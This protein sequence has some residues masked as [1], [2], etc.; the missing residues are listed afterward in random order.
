[1]FAMKRYASHVQV[2]INLLQ[3][4]SFFRCDIQMMVRNLPRL[5]FKAQHAFL[6]GVVPVCI[7]LIVLMLIQS[8]EVLLWYIWM[9]VCLGCFLVGIVQKVIISRVSSHTS[10]SSLSSLLSMA[11]DSSIDSILTNDAWASGLIAGGVLGLMVGGILF[12]YFTKKQKNRVHDETGDKPT[13]ASQ[14]KP[15]KII[16]THPLTEQEDEENDSPQ[17][18]TEE[19]IASRPNMKHL[20]SDAAYYA[21][22]RNEVILSPQIYLTNCFV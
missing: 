1:M 4:V 17:L 9:I 6:V 7:S 22:R 12:W 11:G 8:L 2:L 13:P 10:A 14:E 21:G 16:N 19:L 20:G 15:E 18:S 3:Q 5:D